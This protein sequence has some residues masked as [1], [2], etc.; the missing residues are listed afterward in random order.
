MNQYFLHQERSVGGLTEFVNI[1]ITFMEMTLQ[2]VC[3]MYFNNI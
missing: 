1:H 2:H 3:N